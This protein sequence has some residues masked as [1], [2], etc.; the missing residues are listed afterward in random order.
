M[1]AVTQPQVE[2]SVLDMVYDDMRQRGVLWPTTPTF[3]AAMAALCSQL[4]EL[5]VGGIPG[6]ERNP[7]GMRL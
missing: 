3:Q 2:D 6:E 4:Q 7:L 5:G 1:E